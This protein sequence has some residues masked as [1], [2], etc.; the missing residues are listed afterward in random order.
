[1][2]AGEKSETNILLNHFASIDLHTSIKAAHSTTS[3][4]LFAH[5]IIAAGYSSS[6]RAWVKLNLAGAIAIELA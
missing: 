4:F 1:M 2:F 5:P 6:S 3:S